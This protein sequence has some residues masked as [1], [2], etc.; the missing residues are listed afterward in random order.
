MGD[1]ISRSFDELRV[2]SMITPMTIY[3]LSAKPTIDLATFRMSEEDT[4]LGSTRASS[5]AHVVDVSPAQLTTLF[6]EAYGLSYV[7]EYFVSRHLPLRVV[8]HPRETNTCFEKAELLGHDWS[9]L[10][11]IRAVYLQDTQTAALYAAIVPETGCF[12]DRNRVRQVLGGESELGALE[13]SPVLPRNMILGTCS[14]FVEEEDVRSAS[15]PVTAIVFDSETLFEKKH[16]DTL[17][18]FSLGKDRRMSVQMNYYHCF[19]M[20]KHVYGS[21]VRSEEIMGVKCTERLVRAR[22]RLRLTYDVDT[23]SYRIA[24]RFDE[25]SRS[26]S[27]SISNDHIDEVLGGDPESHAPMAVES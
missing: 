5:L 9:P 1:I 22:G 3:R 15:N 12:L 4:S 2:E 19:K 14:P 27:L 23:A 10:N 20:L 26:V 6:F 21:V 16:D 11:V 24:K 7:V 17:D 18:D 13:V 8:T 25:I